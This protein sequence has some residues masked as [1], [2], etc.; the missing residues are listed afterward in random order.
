MNIARQ[1]AAKFGGIRPLARALDE[2]FPPSTVQGW[3]DSGVIPARRQGA[4]LKAAQRSGVDLTWD[5]FRPPLID[6]PL[7]SEDAA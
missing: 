6:A 1:I 5:D 4:V 3:V 7:T 2:G